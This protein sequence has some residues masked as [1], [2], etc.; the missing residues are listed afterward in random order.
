MNKL[1]GWLQTFSP[2]DREQI[3]RAMDV[4]STAEPV[5]VEPIDVYASDNIGLTE[6]VRCTPPIS[7]ACPTPEQVDAQCAYMISQDQHGAAF[8]LRAL[9]SALAAARE[10]VKLLEGYDA[11]HFRSRTAQNRVIGE[12]A[13]KQ[14][15]LEAERDA[16]RV[17]AKQYYDLWDKERAHAAD[18]AWKLTE[19]NPSRPA[20]AQHPLSQRLRALVV[21][22][23]AG[24]NNTLGCEAA[25]ALDAARE[26]RD[27][28]L[29]TVDNLRVNMQ[30]L[31]AE[32]DAQLE[33][34]A[35]ISL[36]FTKLE[37]DN[38]GLRRDVEVLRHS[39]NIHIGINSKA[40]ANLDK[41]VGLLSEYLFA[42]KYESSKW[43]GKVRALLAEIGKP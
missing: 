4:Y 19:P 8:M 12:Q 32:R 43:T 41:A 20:E 13:E 2:E 36:Q 37:A 7:P 27:E 11:D 42:N 39:I 29:L 17:Q 24:S 31:E 25:A 26:E 5:A 15:A 9:Q 28:Y 6:H 33:T 40:K 1:I 38:E 21:M 10:R 23:E 30:A 34:N 35:V 14:R 22:D 3:K 16:L 18:L